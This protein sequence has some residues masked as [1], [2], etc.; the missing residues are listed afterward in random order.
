MSSF[1][2]RNFAKHY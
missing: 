2:F 1:I